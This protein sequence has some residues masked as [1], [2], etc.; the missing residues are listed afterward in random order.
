MELLRRGTAGLLQGWVKDWPSNLPHPT[1]SSLEE[2]E[3]LHFRE[4]LVSFSAMR[5]SCLTTK[6]SSSNRYSVMVTQAKK[7]AALGALNSTKK[8]QVL[9]Q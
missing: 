1:P 7:G 9:L 3:L 5:N 4:M 2:I 8:K 6:T